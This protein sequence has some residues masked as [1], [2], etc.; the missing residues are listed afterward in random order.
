MDEL[1]SEEKKVGFV[2]WLIIAILI[3]TVLIIAYFA[4]FK[5]SS[6]PD[7]KN[8]SINKTKF[9]TN[10]TR[11]FNNLSNQNNKIQENSIIEPHILNDKDYR[12]LNIT[13]LNVSK[14]EILNISSTVNTTSKNLTDY[15][16]SSA[17]Q[18][19]QELKVY[20]YAYYN[21]SIMSGIYNQYNKENPLLYPLMSYDVQNN[22][23]VPVTLTFISEIQDY[24]PQSIDRLTI[25]ANS[26]MTINQNPLLS[27]NIDIRELTNA[28]IHYSISLSDYVLGEETIPIKLYAKDTMIWG[29][30]YDE[31]FYDSSY[32]IAAWVT[33]HIYEVDELI[34]KSAEHHPNKAI[35]GYQCSSCKNDE[36]WT[37][38]TAAQV[39]AIYDTLKYDYKIAYINAPIAFS[40]NTESSQ[41]VKLPKD[42]IKLSSSNCIDGSVLFASALESIGISPYIILLPEHAFVCW[43]VSETRE[44]IDCLETTMIRDYDFETSE[45]YGIEE[46]NQEFESGNFD[47]NLSIAISI[48]DYRDYGITPII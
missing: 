43:D 48:K 29:Y 36:D 5:E 44:M 7:I 26:T 2:F 8:N 18:D 3:I 25:P 31:Y 15:N 21:P 46:Y 42:S 14:S 12:Q 47:N 40:A 35:E 22:E 41:R 38:Y 16:N 19:S 11:S 4:F 1:A 37:I 28:N 23:S 20:Y 30:F 39:K 27:P 9:S 24:T 10:K 17:S 34:R 32:W 13:A 33:P 6:I 45:E